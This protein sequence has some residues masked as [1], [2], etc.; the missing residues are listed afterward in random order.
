MKNLSLW[1][2]GV[3]LWA[4]SA[5][6]A[7]G[8]GFHIHEQGAKAMGMGNAFVAQADDPS[9]LFYN[10]AGI[11]F[12]EGTQISLGVTTIMVPETEFE[13]STYLAGDTVSGVD[14][15]A[16]KDTFFPRTFISRTQ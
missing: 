13:G 3:F 1:V 2:L 5:G 4:F 12:L 16:R 7:F 11:S 9:A 6:M 15:K 10:P 8:A 14:V